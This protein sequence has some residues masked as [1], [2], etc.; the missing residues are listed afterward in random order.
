MHL[1]HLEQIIFEG[2]H[3]P[4]NRARAEKARF[5]EELEKQE[6]LDRVTEWDQ[7]L[8]IRL[9]RAL[10]LN[11]NLNFV[12]NF[13]P[14]KDNF[15]YM[16]EYLMK[17][18]VIHTKLIKLIKSYKFVGVLFTPEDRDIVVAHYSKKASKARVVANTTFAAKTMIG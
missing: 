4:H 12:K 7:I 8:L 15:Q 13:K 18:E 14:I 1:G 6:G 17:N 10:N 11:L 3:M 2:E 16:F 5:Y 9:N